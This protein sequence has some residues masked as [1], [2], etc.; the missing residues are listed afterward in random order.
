V[1]TSRGDIIEASALLKALDEGLIAGAALDV[2]ATE[3][4]DLSDSLIL[5]PRTIVTPHAAF[6]SEESLEEL[7]ETAATQMAHVLSG[8]LPP[9]VVNPEVLTQ[10]NLRA[11]FAGMRK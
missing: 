4:P 8:K 11:V 9:F 10:S 6:N 2:L 3:P 7:Q 5:H 1:N